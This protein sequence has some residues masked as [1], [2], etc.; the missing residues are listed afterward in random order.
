MERF[1]TFLL[2]LEAGAY[3]TVP[4]AP[5]AAPAGGI[6]LTPLYRGIAGDYHPGQG[7]QYFTN[8]IKLAIGYA[9]DEAK[10]PENQKRGLQPNVIQINVPPQTISMYRSKT[11]NQFSEVYDIPANVVD[12]FSP[13]VMDINAAQQIAAN[14]EQA[15]AINDSSEKMKSVI[16]KG[17]TESPQGLVIHYIIPSKTPGIPGQPGQSILKSIRDNVL[18]GAVTSKVLQQR[19]QVKGEVPVLLVTGDGVFV[20]T[21]PPMAVQVIR[22]KLSKPQVASMDQFPPP[23]TKGR[24][25]MLKTPGNYPPVNKKNLGT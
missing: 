11:T 12:R 7:T 25:D 21:V 4:Q 22:Q 1:K 17:H 19:M 24:G 2:Q 14:Q 8:D 9:M 20:S 15:M 3:P 10:K 13:K 16:F 6:K 18:P 5:G 23:A